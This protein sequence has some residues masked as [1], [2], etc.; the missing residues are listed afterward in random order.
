[1]KLGYYQQ[2]IEIRY[3]ECI[4]AKSRDWQWFIDETDKAFEKP[5]WEDESFDGFKK[6]FYGISRVYGHISSIVEMYPG[7][8]LSFPCEWIHR[9]WE[10]CLIRAGALGFPSETTGDSFFDCLDAV[11]YSVQLLNIVS[12]KKLTYDLGIFTLENYQDLFDLGDL[13][14]EGNRIASRLGEIGKS[15][16]KDTIAIVKN[17][18]EGVQAECD[19]LAIAK[20]LDQEFDANFLN[21]KVSADVPCKTWQEAYFY[22]CLR[23]SYQNDELIPFI[24]FRDGSSIPDFSLMT[25]TNLA[26]M[27]QNIKDARARCVIDSVAYLLHGSKIP[28]ESTELLIHLA[29]KRFEEVSKGARNRHDLNCTSVKLCARILSRNEMS[30]VNKTKLLS[31]VSRVTGALKDINLLATIERIGFSLNKNQKKLLID[32]KREKCSRVDSINEQND[33]L[34]YLEDE[35]VSRFCN[36]T[37]AMK[38]MNKF[39]WFINRT[40]ADV[41]HLFI[42]AANFLIRLL[43]NRNIDNN[44][45]KSRLIHVQSDWSETYY[46]LVLSRMQTFN[47]QFPISNEQYEELD[48]SVMKYPLSFGHWVFPLDEDDIENRIEEISENP[49]AAM[50]QEVKI[51]EFFPHKSRFDSGSD[52]GNNSI[53]KMILKEVARINEKYSF[54]HVNQLEADVLTAQLCARAVRGTRILSSVIRTVPE[55][56]DYICKRISKRYMLIDYPAE[57]E[58]PTLA[59]VCQLF[60]VM[61]NTIRELGKHFSCT[62]FRASENEFHILRDAPQIIG[63]LIGRVLKET[64]TIA[65]TDDLVF[66][67]LIM[68]S[69][70]GLN[71]RNACIHGQGYQSGVRVAEAFRVTVICEYMLLYRLDLVIRTEGEATVSE[72]EHSN[73]SGDDS[74]VSRDDAY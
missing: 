59:H 39:A 65:G 74:I 41:P 2:D 13:A 16:L 38:A 67:Y 72:S 70:N 46:S 25:S 49:L 51:D 48:N 44:W 55:M 19:D 23:T 68:F 66:V 40:E 9:V 69:K 11:S 54:R 22:N 20:V 34:R 4:L 33:L 12:D 36:Q 1:M 47:C 7:L 42:S 5:K 61:E 32:A 57:G 63:E 73:Q 56:Y 30:N 31:G 17:N 43:N 62:P 18:F 71:I 24:R 10:S 3:A 28:E 45:V 15:D 52:S 58:M 64:G 50:I 27:R 14:D 60:P 26:S 21:F 35:D 8:Q 6:A 37:C 29:L 53:D